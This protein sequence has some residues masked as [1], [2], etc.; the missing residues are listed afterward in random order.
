MCK[1]GQSGRKGRRTHS[2]PRLSR[3]FTDS[4]SK[5]A[6]HGGETHAPAIRCCGRHDA[7]RGCVEAAEDLQTTTLALASFLINTF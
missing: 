3:P 5:V 1:S 7:E 2:P 6:H 4:P